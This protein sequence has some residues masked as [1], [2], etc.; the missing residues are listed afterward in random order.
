ME[1]E[2]DLKLTDFV[3]KTI[4]FSE[5]HKVFGGIVWAFESV[6][7]IFHIRAD[8]K[9]PKDFKFIMKIIFV[10]AIILYSVF[11]QIGYVS[12]QTQISPIIL[13]DINANYDVLMACYISYSVILL[14]TIPLEHLPALKTIEESD[15]FKNKLKI[16]GGI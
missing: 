8:M 4:Y 14:T 5:L 3:P 12:F 11:A 1:H 9:K 7:S 10:M 15:L 2:K 13:F 6:T 16:N